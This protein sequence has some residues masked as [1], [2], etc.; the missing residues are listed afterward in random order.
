MDTRRTSS[1]IPPATARLLIHAAKV[2]D[3]SALKSALHRMRA[4]YSGGRRQQPRVALKLQVD[5]LRGLRVDEIDDAG[6]LTELP[7]PPG[8]Y[9]VTATAGSI[10]RGYTLTLEPGLS[11]DLYLHLVPE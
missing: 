6:P 3:E 7:L 9:L 10:R 5:D 8:T 2:P 11:F 4:R 1:A